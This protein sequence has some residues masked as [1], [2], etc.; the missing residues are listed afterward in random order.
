[1]IK[2]GIFNRTFDEPSMDRTNESRFKTIDINL[3]R[4]RLPSK[5]STNA[6]SKLM[7]GAKL[8]GPL[9]SLM[10]RNL[11]NNSALVSPLNKDSTNSFALLGQ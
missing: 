8:Y 11:A 6:K 3:S 5:R 9:S 4:L 10:K 2:S 7:K 1:M